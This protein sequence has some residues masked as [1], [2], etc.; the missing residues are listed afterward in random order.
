MSLV[1]D[2]LSPLLFS[3]VLELAIKTLQEKEGLKLMVLTSC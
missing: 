2:S 1:F 3:F